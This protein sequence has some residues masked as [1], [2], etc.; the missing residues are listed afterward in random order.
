V[1]PIGTGPY[2]FVR[3]DRGRDIVLAVNENYWRE[4]PSI[5]EFAVR[6]I[7]DAQTQI[8]A[9]QAGE[10]DLVLDL[11]PEQAKL[12]PKVYLVTGHRV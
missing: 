6:V 8:S 5:R 10:I 3:W 7:P 1:T 11:L 12:A 4:K 9:L 2:K